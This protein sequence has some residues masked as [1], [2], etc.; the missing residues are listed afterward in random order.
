L[1]HLLVAIEKRHEPPK[2]CY[3]C[4]CKKKG[5]KTS[6]QRKLE[7]AKQRQR[8]REALAKSISSS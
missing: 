6:K 5:K 3:E 2:R 7:R 8:E 4:L 1:K